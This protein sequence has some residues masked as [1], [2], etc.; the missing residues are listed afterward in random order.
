MIK[1]F[2]LLTIFIFVQ[3]NFNSVFSHILHYKKINKLKYDLYRNNQLIGHHIYSFTRDGKNLK[4]TSKI[5]FKIKK[6]GIIFY[7]YFAESEEKYIDD[8]FNSFSSITIQN[9][10]NKFCNI[11]KKGDDFFIEGSSY[12]GKAPD[13]T[14]IGTWWNHLIIES[15]SQISAV[16]GRIIEQNVKYIGKENIKMY[17]KEYTALKFNFSSTDQ[18]LSNKK[19]LDTNVW[20]DE[21]TFIWLKASFKKRGYWEYRLKNY[22]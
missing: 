22:E 14:I 16:S 15:K 13:R 6:M 8:E 11:Y 19:K 5:N 21:K 1:K 3:F 20:Y 17:D 10:K 9:K 4:V 12:T 18:S 7:Q 2:L